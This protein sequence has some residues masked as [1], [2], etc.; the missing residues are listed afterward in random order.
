MAGLGSVTA[1]GVSTTSFSSYDGLGRALASTQ[2]TGGTPY[3]FTYAYYA[4]GLESVTYPSTRQI[5]YTYDVAGRILSVGGAKTYAS[6]LIYASFGGLQSMQYGNNLYEQTCYNPRLQAT[7]VWVNSTGSNDCTSPSSND[8]LN[9]QFGFAASPHNN[10]NLISQSIYA[11][12]STP[13]AQS[14]TYNDGL[15]RLS[16]ATETSGWTQTY[17]YDAY[18]NRAVLAGASQY[19]PNTNQTP[20]T[21]STT[22]VPYNGSNQWTQAGYD[23]SGNVTSDGLNSMTY[24][25]DNLLQTSYNSNNG[26]VTYY[27]DGDGHR[28]QKVVT[29]GATTTYVYDAQ[30]QL[31]AEYA[32]SAPPALC[33]TCWLTADHLGST[34]MLTDSNGTVQRRYDFLPFGEEIPQ[35]INGRTAPYEEGLQ[36]TMPDTTD[37][38]FTAKSRDSES[39]LDFFGARY[40]SGSQGRF[41]TPDPGRITSRVLANPQRWNR[42]GYVVNSPHARVDPDG[43]QDF[44]APSLQALTQMTPHQRELYEQQQSYENKGSL[45]GGGIA[46]GAVGA[47]LAPETTMPIFRGLMAWALGHPQEVQEAG[48]GIAE[49]LSGAPPGSLTSSFARLGTTTAESVERKLSQYLL[50]TEHETG[51]TKAQW[52]EQALG[53]TRSNMGDLAKQIV[54]DPNTAVETGVTQYG[55]QYNQVI[56][57]VGA[58]G[59][60]IDVTFAWIQNTDDVVRLV[61]AI[62]TK[63]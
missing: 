58:N 49:G 33:A 56:S 8:L 32:T 51:G 54:F 19:V 47:A 21:S 23:P 40:F 16:S 37:V 42:Y 28:V 62:P 50:N 55:T 41:T 27:Y 2:T 63:Q 14:Y 53:F 52:F 44:A 35:G 48:A 6:G 4:S 46:L 1:S 31:A 12:S 36:L 59:N 15:N 29:G 11:S 57:I 7:A 30:G 26:L 18:G 60:T 34:R 25:A 61:T 24:Y 3:P 17:V 9:L 13:Y 38:K 20:Q 43:A 22:W 5:S 39:N 45:I 10:G